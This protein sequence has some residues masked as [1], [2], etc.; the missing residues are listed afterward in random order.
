MTPRPNFIVLLGDRYGWRPLPSR[1]EKAEFEAI[2]T[3]VSETGGADSDL[4]LLDRWYRLDENADPA[5]YV[6]LPRRVDV[7]ERPSVDA[8]EAAQDAEGRQW[9]AIEARMRAILLAAV[10]G[11]GWRGADPR[12]AKYVTSATEQEIVRGALEAKDAADHVFGFNRTISMSDGRPLADAAPPDGSA[13][14]FLDETEIKGRWVPD[15][16][17]HDRLVV[18]KEEK[19]RP[20]L[21]ANISDYTATW[22]G[23]G[24]T[25]AVGAL[26]HSLDDC[27]KLLEDADL[28]HALCTDVWRNLATMILDQLEKLESVEAVE[29]EI[30]AHESFGEDRCSSFFG[31]TDPLAAIAKYLNAKEQGPLAVIGEPGSGK[32]ALIAK[33]FEQAK[34]AHS[35]A[36]ALVRF[37]GTTPGSSDGRTF[38]EHVCLQIT[39]HTGGKSR[40]CQP[41]TT[42]WPSSSASASSS[43]R[44]NGPSSSSLTRSISSA[45]PIRLA[46]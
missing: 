19:L 32:S 28:S 5:E 40:P 17:A 37:I 8:L 42:T 25:R 29:A 34:A 7:P 38:L 11:L 12:R 16:S 44:P 45:L 36:L 15:T 31:R 14:H 20:L 4:A 30:A 33:A 3:K 6:L 39:G 1:I 9:R 24:T 23:S 18:L 22:N 13:R 21:G 2:L 35:N 10:D 27:L 41:S 46:P 43:R 26:P